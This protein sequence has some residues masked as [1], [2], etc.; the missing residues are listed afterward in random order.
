L[1]SDQT[2]ANSVYTARCDFTWL[3]SYVVSGGVSPVLFI[4]SFIQWQTKVYDIVHKNKLKTREK[5]LEQ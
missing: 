5:K 4:H 1:S 2:V 3:S